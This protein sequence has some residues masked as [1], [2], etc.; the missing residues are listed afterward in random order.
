MLTPHEAREPRLPARIDAVVVGASA[1]AIEALG[2]VLAPLPAST[3]WPVLVVVHLP[4][5]QPSLLAALFARRCAVRVREALDKEALTA[6][7]WFAPAD[8]HVLVESGRT[9]ALS[10]GEPVNHSRPSVDVLFES[11][12][13]AYGDGLVAIV[14]T[15]A[16]SDGAN[17]AKAVRDAGGYVIV[18]DPATAEAATMPSE[19]IERSAP[20]WVAGLEEIGRALRDA[21]L[22][23]QS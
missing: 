23:S 5:N 17:G 16:S 21:A 11:A 6:G 12:A 19:A 8:Y 14:L 10:I 13:L 15:G 7:I 20:Q 2:E 1:G 3:P 22:E 9:L 4:A 18:Q